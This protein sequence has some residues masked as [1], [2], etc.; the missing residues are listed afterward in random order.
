MIL[1]SQSAAR[2]ALLRAAG[3]TFEQRPSRID[4]GA[5]KQA[6]HESG[7]DACALT[8]AGLKAARIRSPDELVIGADQLL[9]C[10]DEWFDKPPDQ[11][12][13]RAQLLRLRGCEHTLV[14][15]VVCHRAGNEIWRH[16]ARPTLRMRQ[17]S[18]AFLDRYLVAEGDAV[19]SS[20]GAYRLEGLGIQLFDRIEG[21]YAAILGLPLLALLGFL[22]QHG[23]LEA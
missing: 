4:E 7:P 23:A 2:A 11:A 19:L 12:A 14:T 17:F 6:M 15:A 8:L 5:I 3:L 18:E 22:R 21:E 20:V 10:G 1:A 13:A 9:V 16:V